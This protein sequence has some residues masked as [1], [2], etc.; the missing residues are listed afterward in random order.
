MRAE[1]LGPV[2]ELGPGYRAQRKGTRQRDQHE[3]DLPPVT[4]SGLFARYPQ[5]RR[6]GETYSVEEAPAAHSRAIDQQDLRRQPCCARSDFAAPFPRSAETFR[7]PR[8]AAP[9]EIAVIF[10][11]LA[12]ARL[13]LKSFVNAAYGSSQ[14]RISSGP[15]QRAFECGTEFVIL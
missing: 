11:N 1:L 5:Q 2:L 8:V 13:W 12:S 10:L 6:K 14:N 9:Q 3:I 7:G 15:N 4:I